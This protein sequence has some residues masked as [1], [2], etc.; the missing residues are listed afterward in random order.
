VKFPFFVRK[1]TPKEQEE[2][3]PKVD[4]VL[5]TATD[6]NESTLSKDYLYSLY[7]ASSAV[8]N[9]VDSIAS[10]VSSASYKLEGKKKDIEAAKEFLEQPNYN[11][12]TYRSFVYKVV[13]DLLVSDTAFIEKV[14]SKKNT[15]YELYPRNPV[16]FIVVRDKYGII[17]GYKQ[18][19]E[20]RTIP[21]EKK[22]IIFRVLHPSSERVYGTPIIESISDEIAGVILTTDYIY[23][24]IAQDSIPPGV[25]LFGGLD[26]QSFKRAKEELKA[27][28]E[29]NEGPKVLLMRGNIEPDKL[30]F[31]NLK[32]AS[33]DS[34][35]VGMRKLIDDIIYRA[36][37]IPVAESKG[38]GSLPTFTIQNL[39]RQSRLLEPLMSIIEDIFNDEVF[40]RELKLDCKLR[41]S[42]KGLQ[43][44]EARDVRAYVMTGV[45]SVNEMRAKIGEEPIEGGDKHYLVIGSNV[46]EI[47]KNGLVNVTLDLM[48][49]GNK[50]GDLDTMDVENEPKVNPRRGEESPK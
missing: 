1:R 21:F 22:D 17:T 13:V 4:N 12:E 46:F 15:L 5:S 32:D 35:I 28:L 49:G 27:I 3:E 26:K 23:R 37:A 47:T 16:N 6:A 33:F 29:N 7:R 11:N 20:G 24:S 2:Q 14:R 50:K 45:Q 10:I 44:V 19:V 36:F 30:K 43:R 42:R 25:F 41:I 31:V 18:M 48:N 9:C 39:A 34:V 40:G 8:R 38:E